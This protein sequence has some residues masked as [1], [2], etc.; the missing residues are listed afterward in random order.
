[1]ERILPEAPEW[2]TERFSNFQKSITGTHW[3]FG[4]MF[5]FSRRPLIFTPR[6]SLHL[7]YLSLLSEESFSF[8]SLLFLQLLFFL[9]LFS[10]SFL[11]KQ[12]PLGLVPVLSFQSPPTFSPTILSL[13]SSLQLAG[14]R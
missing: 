6:I 3:H 4:F 14:V 1:M 10:S 13:T 5:G 7:F 12:A 2:P 8:S 9:L 11:K